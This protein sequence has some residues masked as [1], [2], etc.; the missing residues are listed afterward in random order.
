MIEVR[1]AGPGLSDGLLRQL[2]SGQRFNLAEGQRAGTD[3][4]GLGLTIVLEIMKSL[5]GRVVLSNRPGGGLS[6]AL[7]IPDRQ[8]SIES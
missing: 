8:R 3:S 7:H 2:A 1:D 5:G 4:T 6:A